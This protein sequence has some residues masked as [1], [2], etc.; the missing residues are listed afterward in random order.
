MLIMFVFTVGQNLPQYRQVS[1]NRLRDWAFGPLPP[2]GGGLGS[3]ARGTSSG[4]R[5]PM[6]DDGETIPFLS[7]TLQPDI[8]K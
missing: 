8:S 4:V 2:C 6:F 1:R 5:N 3:G 7:G